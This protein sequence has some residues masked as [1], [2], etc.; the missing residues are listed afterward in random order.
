[1]LFQL[2][3]LKMHFNKVINS[4]NGQNVVF[5]SWYLNQSRNMKN[6]FLGGVFF[7]NQKRMFLGLKLNSFK[8]L[9]FK[10]FYLTFVL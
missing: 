3:F 5:D 9:N 10:L 4:Q 6:K 1:M 2:I 7:K 8:N